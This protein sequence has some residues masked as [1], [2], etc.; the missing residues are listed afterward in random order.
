[1]TG[2]PAART[3]LRQ[4]ARLCLLVWCKACHDQAPAGQGDRPLKDLKVRCTKCRSSLADSVVMARDALA[5]Q[6]PGGVGRGNSFI[7]N[8]TRSCRM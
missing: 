3:M 2:L 1:V 6:P 8:Q 7:G 5:A 4:D